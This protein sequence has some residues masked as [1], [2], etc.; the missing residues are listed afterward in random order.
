MGG[1]IKLSRKDYYRILGVD[2][3]ATP[4]EIKKAYRKLS[5]LHHPD[6]NRNDKKAEEKFKEIN[7]AYSVL[8][9][10][11]ARKNYD[12]PNPFGDIGINIFGGGFNPFG[13]MMRR[14]LP[15]KG[16]DLKFIVSIPLS[17]FI[18]GGRVDFSF[19]YNDVCEGCSG[20][21]ATVF[22]TCPNCDGKG[23]E[24]KEKTKPGV[25]MKSTVPC[26]ACRG[27]GEIPLNKCEICRGIGRV[28]VNKTV[29]FDV[30]ENTEDGK[31][32]SLKG[33]GCKGI[34]GGP[35]GDIHL[36]LKMILPNV[37]DLTEEQKEVLKGL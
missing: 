29:N 19:S 18:F 5:L 2:R 4:E 11:D 35:N 8:S 28:K 23:Y 10:E 30:L 31:L 13:D 21:R 24:V 9:D 26:G 27:L 22:K 16:K 34:N 6:K 33:E 25:F 3:K 17:K 7:E 12:N 37:K 15:R 14:D 36:K 20:K 32:M 1:C